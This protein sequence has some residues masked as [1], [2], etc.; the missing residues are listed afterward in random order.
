M[1]MQAETIIHPRARFDS[2]QGSILIGRRCIIHE[3]AQIGSQQSGEGHSLGGVTL[4]D[5][6]VVEV[7]S[8]IESGGTEIGE[9]CVIQVGSKIGS[10]AK[11]GKV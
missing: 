10:G 4:G 6:V 7:G 2:T 1:T 5:Y 11:L 3:R 9:G 8:V